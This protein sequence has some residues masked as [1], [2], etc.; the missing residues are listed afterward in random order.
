MID[1]LNQ[2]SYGTKSNPEILA[3]R[4]EWVDKVRASRDQ[5]ASAAAERSREI[6]EKRSREILKKKVRQERLGD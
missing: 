2:L 6:E 1:F 3:T 5:A 4:Q